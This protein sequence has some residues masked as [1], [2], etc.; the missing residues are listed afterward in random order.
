MFVNIIH[1]PP[2]V[3]GQDEA[4]RAWF[5]W[6]NDQYQSHQGFI[7]RKIGRAHV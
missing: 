4:F 3:K 1:F 2:V 6:S 5:V 7:S